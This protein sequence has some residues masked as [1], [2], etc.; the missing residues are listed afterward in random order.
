MAESWQNAWPPLSDVKASLPYNLALYF[1]VTN[2]LAVL[3]CLMSSL[4]YAQPV[5]SNLMDCSY[6]I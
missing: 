5:V 2:L 1:S 3:L 6:V 4:A